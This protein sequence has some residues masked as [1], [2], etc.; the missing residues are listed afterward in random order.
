MLSSTINNGQIG[1]GGQIQ[2]VENIFS[3]GS[4]ENTG[5]ATDLAI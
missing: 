3:Q 2:A 4:L 5:S 1:R